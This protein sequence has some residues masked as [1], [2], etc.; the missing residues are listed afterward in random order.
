MQ[1]K[2][3]EIGEDVLS[4]I[5]FDSISKVKS[6]LTKNLTPKVFDSSGPQHIVELC[7]GKTAIVSRA[8]LGH[9]IFWGYV[10]NPKFSPDWNPVTAEK[11]PLQ[12]RDDNWSFPKSSK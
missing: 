3:P 11:N 1:T 6:I 7:N 5:E 12:I 4:R 8:A 9:L 2:L 10:N